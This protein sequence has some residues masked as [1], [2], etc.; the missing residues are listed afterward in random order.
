MDL[1]FSE[2]QQELVER[3]ETMCTQHCSAELE[4]FRDRD[5]TFPDDVYRALADTGVLAHRLP[6]DYGGHGGSLLDC[7]LIG[8]RLGRHSSLA[9]SL[10]FVNCVCA[11]LI[12]RA[13]HERQKSATVW[14]A[15]RNPSGRS[16]PDRGSHNCR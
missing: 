1:G 13:G 16:A 5:N 9:I 6:T 7:I 11:E 4:S 15:Y 12:A 2:Y 3:V 8:N 14:A 10:Y